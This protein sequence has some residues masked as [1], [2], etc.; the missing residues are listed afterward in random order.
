VTPSIT[1]AT[2]PAQRAEQDQAELEDRGW[3]LVELVA[4]GGPEAPEAFGELY[5][6]YHETVLRYVIFRTRHRETA[7]DLTAD[8]FI[9]ALSAVGNGRV[10]RQGV[11]F[12]AYLTTAARNRIADRY[13]S[14][15]FQREWLTGDPYPLDATDVDPG[16]DPAH[17]AVTRITNAELR[18]AMSTLRPDH[19]RCLE[20]RFMYELTDKQTAAR[21]GKQVGAI[22]A[23]QYRATRALR[24]ALEAEGFTR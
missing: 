20:L 21:M 2:I 22:K 6:R 12:G 4:A 8:V 14:A 10:S 13:K 19:R 11:D 17:A 15:Q 9:K 24:R 16:V 3:A 1:T 7:E 23:L 5:R 18:A